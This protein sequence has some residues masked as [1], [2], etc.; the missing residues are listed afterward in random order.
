MRKF[1]IVLALLSAVASRPANAYV[2]GDDIFKSCRT[3]H[4]VQMDGEQEENNSK[5]LFGQ[6]CLYYVAGVL[7][8]FALDVLVH[9]IEKQ[10]CPG[11]ANTGDM[12]EVVAK[13]ILEHPADRNN[14][15]SL[16]VVMALREAYPCV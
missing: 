15:V 6:T 8:A 5:T 14:P 2:T 1:M 7:D 4:Q 10:Y 9:K 16:I 3:F 11:T 12:T 13:F